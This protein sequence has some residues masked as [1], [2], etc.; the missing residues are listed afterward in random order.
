MCDTAKDFTEIIK[1]SQSLI[2]ARK[3]GTKFWASDFSKHDYKQLK[4]FTSTKMNTNNYQSFSDYLL[5]Y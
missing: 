5:L 4:E 2:V 1:K 3:L